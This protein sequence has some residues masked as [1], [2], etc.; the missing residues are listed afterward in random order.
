MAKTAIVTGAGSGVG[1]AVA[2]QLAGE[3]WNV[4]LVGRRAD[5]LRQTIERAGELAPRMLAIPCDVTNADQVAKLAAAVAQTFGA[6]QLLV[7]AA[8]INIPNRSWDVLSVEDYRHVIDVNLNGTFNCVRALLPGMRRQGNGS[9]VVIVSDAG[10]LASAKSGAAYVASKFGLRGLVQS[11]NAE[12]RSHGIRATAILPG[13]IN[14]PL[15]DKRPA[16]PPPAARAE[17]LQPQD[18]AA[19]VMLA[20][21]LPRRAIVEE[22]LIRPR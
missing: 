20:V 9:V 2:L 1:Q 19:C 15:L 6:A 21:N 14:T 7:S 18:I 22:L 13:D 11:L 12:E 5:A 16:P 3:G 4:G 8:G 17:M 10:L